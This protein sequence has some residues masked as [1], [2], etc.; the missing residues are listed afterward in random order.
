MSEVASRFTFFPPDERQSLRIGRFLMAAGTSLLM[1][2]ALVI[3]AFLGLLPWSVALEGTTGVATLI[4]LFYAIFRSGL[5]RRFAD[6]SLTTEQIGAAILFLA[7]IM[8][9][10]GEVREAL[11]LFYP[12]AMLFGVLRLSVARL[13]GLALLGLAAHGTVLHLAYLD[14]P[15]MDAMAALTEF[16]VLMIVLPWFAVMGGYVNRLRVRLTD[17]HRSLKQ[18]LDQIAEIAVR[19]ELTGVYNR[20]F[21]LEALARE[22]SRAARLSAPVSVCLI[23]IDHFKAINDSL[24]HAA[25]DAVLRQLPTVVAGALRGLDVFGRFGGEEFLLILPGTG[26]Q[27]ARAA[28]ERLRGAV[29]AASFEGMPGGRRVSVTIGLA[30]LA[31]GEDLT[32]L[33][34]RADRALY[35][36]KSAGRN[37]VAIG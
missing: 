19:D 21:L 20:R 32:G 25:G 12:V 33:L 29:E 11:T 34:A 17:S 36:G 14:E 8:H 7:Y 23:D 31:K 6:P 37:Q 10:A 1:C 16:A 28:A 26:V 22:H 9:H 35:E 18:A 4:L 24:G 5:N 15:N 2:V 30:E 13:M 27:G 3:C